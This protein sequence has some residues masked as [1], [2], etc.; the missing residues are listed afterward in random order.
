MRRSRATGDGSV[1]PSVDGNGLGV[2]PVPPGRSEA[3]APTRDSPFD[4]RALVAFFVLAYLLNWAWVIPL[5]A[6]GRTVAQGHGWPTH[7]P[8][9]LAPLAAAFIVTAWTTGRSGIRDL[10][11]RMG[12]W[13]IGWHWW[14]AALS[15]LFFL[16][17]AIA[18]IAAV[19]GALPRAGEFARFS[20]L[21]SGLGPVGV[22]LVIVVVNGF[23]EET[24]W[25]GYALPQLQKRFSPLTSTLILAGLWG[26]WHI[27]MFFTLDSY[28]G[29]SAGTA[30][31]FA[32]GLMCGAVVA[33]WLYNHTGGSILAVVLWH[34]LYN[35]AS[36]TKAATGGSAAIAAVV[37]T[38]IMVQAVVLVGLEIRAGRHGQHSVLG[39]P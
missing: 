9:L 5:A 32:F 19:G 28:R 4:P 33:T 16:G 6:T 18:V 27:P 34:G 36:G 30:A 39:P 31:G 35:V 38:M 20:G 12:R 15:P 3:G 14:I 17:F 13:R 7:F 23:G 26:G 1:A 22:A 10:L 2:C 8:G 37:S 24:G 29:F 21:P 11:R 25:R